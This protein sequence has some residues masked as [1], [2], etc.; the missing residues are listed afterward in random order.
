MARRGDAKAVAPL[1]KLVSDTTVNPVVRASAVGLVGTFPGPI[2]AGVLP[3]LGSDSDPF[4]RM[5]TARA[6]G[7]VDG[8]DSVE[9]LAHLVKDRYRVVRIQAAAA[10]VR[11]SFAKGA[12]S[13]KPD[14]PAF[15]AFES[16]LAEYR[17]SLGVEND[18]PEVLVELVFLELFA[19]QTESASKAYRQALALDGRMADAFYGL[20]LTKLTQNDREEALK[21][22]KRAFELSGEEAHRQLRD[23]LSGSRP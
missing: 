17:R 15:P 19:V 6:L 3:R 9:A 13:L 7:K 10:L 21:N 12:A 23:R 11:L 8:G 20:A 16:A 2:S 18:L 22:A 1:L 14:H 5:E 4:V